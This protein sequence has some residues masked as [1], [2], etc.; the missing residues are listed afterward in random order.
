[1][2]NNRDD[3]FIITPAAITIDVNHPC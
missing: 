1:L 3:L 2:R